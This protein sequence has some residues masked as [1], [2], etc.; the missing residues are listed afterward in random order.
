MFLVI[1]F[2]IPYSHNMGSYCEWGVDKIA[3]D[4]GTKQEGNNNKKGC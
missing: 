4:H 1:L 3:F 2:V